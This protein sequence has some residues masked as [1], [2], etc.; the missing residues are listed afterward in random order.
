MRL[1]TVG[2]SLHE[3]PSYGADGHQRPCTLAHAHTRNIKYK[4]LGQNRRAER[5]APRATA[6]T[7]RRPTAQLT[8]DKT[9]H[10]SHR[11]PSRAPPQGLGPGQRLAVHPGRDVAAAVRT[12]QVAVC[13]TCSEIHLPGA[14]NRKTIKLRINPGLTAL[15]TLYGRAPA[16]TRQPSFLTWRYQLVYTRS[17]SP[18]KY[19]YPGAVSRCLRGSKICTSTDHSST[20]SS[21]GVNETCRS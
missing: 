14:Q 11:P 16:T 5:D 19:K 12:L 13:K 20:E 21:A 8:R 18:I 4:F 1:V 2:R 17:V 15:L 6:D 10:A 7:P 3:P 9:H